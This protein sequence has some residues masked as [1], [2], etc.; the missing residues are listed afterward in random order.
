MAARQ[1]QK[2]SEPDFAIGFR[3]GFGKAVSPEK[4]SFE[5]GRNHVSAR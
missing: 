4:R 1:S 5:A 2:G 3:K